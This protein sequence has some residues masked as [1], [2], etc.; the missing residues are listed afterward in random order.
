LLQVNAA[1]YQYEIENLSNTQVELVRAIISSETQFTAMRIMQ[2]SRIGT[3]QNV[4]KNIKS[5]I[6]Q[7]IIEKYNN[8][9]ELIDPAL[10]LWFKSNFMNKQLEIKC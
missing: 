10:E 5:L 6:N 9:T 4:S 8:R 2:N 1:L 3:P 7:D